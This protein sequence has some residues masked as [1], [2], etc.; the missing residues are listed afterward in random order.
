M[1]YK[2]N[3]HR[4]NA[5]NLKSHTP[6]QIRHKKRSVHIQATE[7]W[8]L[9][10]SYDTDILKVNKITGAIYFDGE[11]YSKTTKELQNIVER[12]LDEN[13][14]QITNRK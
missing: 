10:K 11:H 5:V 7:A 8:I 4:Q 1:E 12:W 14:L 2:S 3:I 9:A 6:L 13:G